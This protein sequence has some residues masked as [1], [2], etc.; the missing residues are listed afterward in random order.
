MRESRVEY[1]A[2]KGIEQVTGVRRGINPG[3]RGRGRG[4]AADAEG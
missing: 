1:D 3:K 2:R 4:Q